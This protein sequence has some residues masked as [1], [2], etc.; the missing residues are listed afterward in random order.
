LNCDELEV[1]NVLREKDLLDIE[2]FVLH[3]LG[4]YRELILGPS[5]KPH[6]PQ[7]YYAIVR[8]VKPDIVVETGV[9]A[10]ISSAY[11][12]KALAKN[13]QGILYSIDLPDENILM[14]IPRESRHYIDSG[15]VIPKELKNRWRLIIG[16][17]RDKLPSLLKM[18]GSID[19]FVHDSEH[20]YENM[21]FKYMTAW[22]HLKEGGILLS[23]DTNL[24]KAFIDFSAKVGSKFI[25]LLGP[26]SGIRKC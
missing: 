1:K 3:E 2:K 4:E 16:R 6:K 20:S 8:L 24:N 11:I 26:V 18:P 10:G 17:S 15:W 13:N 7:I 21:M 14:R 19:I 22:D 25:R 12:L 9:Q 5:T 23:D